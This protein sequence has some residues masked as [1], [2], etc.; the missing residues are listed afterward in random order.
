MRY[1]KVGLDEFL[2]SVGNNEVIESIA[3]ESQANFG[4]GIEISEDAVESDYEDG[5]DSIDEELKAIAIAMAILERLWKMNNG[6]K[7]I[8]RDCQ[9]ELGLQ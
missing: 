2:N 1:S 9:K 6:A 8:L 3:P 5:A 4:A 7:K